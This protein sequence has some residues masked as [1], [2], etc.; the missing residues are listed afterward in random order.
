MED[1][2]TSLDNVLNDLILSIEKSE[3]GI[4]DQATIEQKQTYGFASSDDG[5]DRFSSSKANRPPR[6]LER[7]FGNEGTATLSS[8]DEMEDTDAM[9]FESIWNEDPPLVSADAA[10]GYC[11]STYHTINSDEESSTA[12]SISQRWPKRIGII[13]AIQNTRNTSLSLDEASQVTD[14]AMMLWP[15]NLLGGCAGE[16]NSKTN[17]EGGELPSSRNDDAATSSPS[18]QKKLAQRI[19]A[20][21]SSFTRNIPGKNSTTASM[22]A[23]TAATSNGTETTGWNN[24]V[25]AQHSSSSHIESALGEESVS[26]TLT[27]EN[28]PA[29]KDQAVDPRSLL[30]ITIISLAVCILLF[31]V[32]LLC[33]L[34]ML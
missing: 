12:S 33:I 8:E 4:D 3:D 31:L 26:D 29:P 10:G 22:E 15:S 11:I 1:I 17:H 21:G 23:E 14:H 27:E 25:E 24:D 32:A 5:I 16:T 19:E 34:I 7:L 20:L 18:L 30:W 13:G 28:F 2:I 9:G 6:T